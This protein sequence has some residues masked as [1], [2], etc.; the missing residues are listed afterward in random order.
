MEWVNLGHAT[1]AEIKAEIENKPLFSEIF[2]KQSHPCGSCSD[3][4]ENCTCTQECPDGFRPVNAMYAYAECL[5]VKPGK[6]KAAS[7]LESRR[8]CGY[9]GGTT[10]FRKMEGFS[11]DAD[12]N[13]AYLGV[14]SA[15]RGMADGYSQKTNRNTYDVGGPNH[16]QI[17]EE[18]ICGC[19]FEMPV[20]SS[21]MRFT[22]MKSLVCGQEIEED[23][24]GNTC[25][26]DSIAYPDNLAV[27]HGHNGLLIGEDGRGHE[28]DDEDDEDDGE[29]E[30]E[31]E[32][33][34]MLKQMGLPTGFT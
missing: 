34:K 19:V 20:D 1:A 14:S 28:N 23:A 29:A 15:T 27:V 22:S 6:E 7:R 16:I 9:M 25:H 32:E 17:Q 12:S 13:K 2:E 11:F 33:M 24:N 18:N 4:K 30:E 8:Y 21:N 31:T 5:Q 26:L 10:E 3:G